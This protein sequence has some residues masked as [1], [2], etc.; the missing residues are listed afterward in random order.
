MGDKLLVGLRLTTFPFELP[1]ADVLV[2]AGTDGKI[3]L[4]L[5]VAGLPTLLI[6]LVVGLLERKPLL[7]LPLPFRCAPATPPLSKS[8]IIAP[9][10]AVLRSLCKTVQRDF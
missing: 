3:G 5:G 8:F 7:F 4:P 6:S 9:L 1:F 10:N 2:L